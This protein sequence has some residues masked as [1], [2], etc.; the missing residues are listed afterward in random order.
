MAKSRALLLAPLILASCAPTMMPPNAGTTDG[1]FLQAVTGSN[2]FEI[3]SSQVALKQSGSD[4]VKAFAQKLI[5]D[6]TAAQAQVST[7]AASKGV[8]LPTALPPEL[9]LKVNTLSTLSGAAFD[10]AYLNE[11]VL[12]HQFTLSLLQNEQAAG[13]DADVV[14]LATAQVPVITGHLQRAQELQGSAAP[15]APSTP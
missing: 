8:M 5:D 13:K 7:L 12:A 9:Q 4:A 10:A 1:L 14:A 2:L 6:H 15:A 11:Q 3:Q